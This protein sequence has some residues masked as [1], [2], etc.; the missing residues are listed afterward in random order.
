VRCADCLRNGQTCYAAR[1]DCE[2]CNG[3]GYMEKIVKTIESLKALPDAELAA[4]VARVVMQYDGCMDTFF[5]GDEEDPQSFGHKEW[6][7]AYSWGVIEDALDRRG[8]GEVYSRN[9]AGM[10]C[11]VVGHLSPAVEVRHLWRLIRA[12][13]RD[14]C[15]A[16]VLAAQQEG[17]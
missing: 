17:P 7:L 10:T 15:I 2:T 14:R 1:R 5:V 4:E 3:S 16:A 9:L 6:C 11:E 8:L 12:P 13:L